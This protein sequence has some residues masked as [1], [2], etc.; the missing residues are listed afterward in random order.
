M[1][2]RK[3]LAVAFALILMVGAMNTTK[4]S[5]QTI[6]F[7]KCKCDW[8]VWNEQYSQIQVDLLASGFELS[9]IYDVRMT[10]KIDDMSGGCGGGYV[11]NSE[12]GGWDQKE[13][14]NDGSGK[15]I[16]LVDLGDGLYTVAFGSTAPL[17][18]DP[19]AWAQV[20]ISAWWGPDFEIVKCELIGA[21]GSVLATT[22]AETAA[23]I[24]IAPA[25][26]LPQTG[27]VSSIVLFA[28]GACL[29]AGGSVMVKKNRKEE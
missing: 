18:T 5:A 16:T 17:Y 26:G 15:A 21:D 13:W 11:L 27:V 29:V 10:L 1:K 28:A 25:P 20:V 3:V 14:G 12:K 8:F 24:L 19:G 7:D 6:A 4:A 9:Q 22:P 2:L 23:P